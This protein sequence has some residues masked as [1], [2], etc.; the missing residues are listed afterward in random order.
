MSVQLKWL[1]TRGSS[2]LSAYQRT[3]MAKVGAHHIL[4]SNTDLSYS[5]RSRYRALVPGGPDHEIRF[6]RSLYL[7]RAWS[8]CM[9]HSGLEL[10][11]RPWWTR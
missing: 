9:S 11:R 1:T 2:S 5:Q 6:M 4:T 10:A 3:E 8:I 7:G